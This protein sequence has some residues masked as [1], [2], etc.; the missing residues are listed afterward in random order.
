M[1]QAR[2]R[3][4]IAVGAIAIA[5]MIVGYLSLGSI[6]KTLST[7]GMFHSYWT[8][9]RMLLALPSDLGA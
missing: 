5:G 8:R 7:S 3:P 1:S 9:S 6:E 2:T 4:W